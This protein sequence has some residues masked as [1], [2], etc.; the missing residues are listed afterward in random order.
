MRGRKAPLIVAG[1][2]LLA[3]LAAGQAGAAKPAVIQQPGEVCQDARILVAI[4][5]QDFANTFS[6]DSHSQEAVD[7]D[8]R[9]DRTA[10]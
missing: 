1:F 7:C 2:S 3:S 8:R 5:S 6:H 4:P 9:L 10:R